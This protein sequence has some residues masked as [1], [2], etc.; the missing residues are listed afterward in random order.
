VL[1]CDDREIAAPGPERAVVFQ[2]HSLLPWMTCFEIVLLGVE[3]V[4]GKHERRRV[5]PAKAG[6]QSLRTGRDR[7]RGST[8]TARFAPCHS[9]VT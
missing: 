2:N 1:L 4:F 8:P 9:G 6:I 3:S 7:S 5:I